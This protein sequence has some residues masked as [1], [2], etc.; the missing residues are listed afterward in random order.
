MPAPLGDAERASIALRDARSLRGHRRR[1]GPRR[2]PSTGPVSRYLGRLALTLARP[3]DAV[4]HLEDASRAVDA[5]GRPAVRGRGEPLDLAEALLRRGARRET[6]SGRSSCS[7]ACLDAAQELGMRLV[8]RARPRA[9]ARGPGARR[10]RRHD[11]DRH[12][13]LGGRERAPRHRAR[14]PPPDG[15]VTILFSDIENSTLMT[16]RLGDERWIEVLRAHNSVFREHLRAHGGYEV[17]NQGDGF[18]LVFPDPRRGARVR[19]RDPARARR[20]GGRRRRAD[21]RAD[22]AARRRGD[23][24]GGRLLRPQRDPR[25]ADRGPGGRRRD[26]RLLLVE[27]EGGGVRRVVRQRPRAGAQ[28]PGRHPRGLPRALGCARPAETSG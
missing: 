21:P 25:R 24:R 5:D 22:G 3:G 28:G 7:D 20:A 15:T 27:G 23:P 6:A 13:D 16:E 1:R 11:L 2:R 18:M 17:K 14:S 19:G 10:R 12:R 8:D 4:R 9:A 26:P